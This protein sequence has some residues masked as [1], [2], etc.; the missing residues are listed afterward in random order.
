MKSK[1][2]SVQAYIAACPP[3]SRKALK[4]LR[5]LVRAAAPRATEK[6]SYGIP[7]FVL[8]GQYLVYIAGW[9]KHLSM[10]P[11]TAGVARE[12][13]EEIKP[14]R[15]GKGTLQFPLANPLPKGLIRRIVKLRVGEVAE[16]AH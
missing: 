6:I 7:T 9:K 2:R 12:L 16:R 1:A 11:V 4:Q 5:T 15:T 10:Y 13:K 14:Y 8:D 3:E